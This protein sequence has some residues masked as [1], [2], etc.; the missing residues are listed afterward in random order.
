MLSP[1]LGPQ[2][3][4][5]GKDLKELLDKDALLK[6]IADDRRARVNRQLPDPNLFYSGI[7]TVSLL[8]EPRT[9]R[10]RLPVTHK[11][12]RTEVLVGGRWLA[13]AAATP[14]Q[15]E[16]ALREQIE[17]TCKDELHLQHPQHPI[18][19]DEWEEVQKAIDSMIEGLSLKTASPADLDEIFQT[20]GMP[21]APAGKPE[22]KVADRR[23][24]KA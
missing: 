12:V 17:K 15:V 13:C 23:Q 16:K 9:R 14:E 5:S 4:V 1:K 6:A 3:L 20:M 21:G 18:S 7:W 11:L 2:W 22:L 10:L 19:V 24:S 8:E